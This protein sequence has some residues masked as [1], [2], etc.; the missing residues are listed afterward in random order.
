MRGGKKNNG[1]LVHFCVM[2]RNVFFFV[3]IF[4][5]SFLVLNPDDLFRTS[6]ATPISVYT[7]IARK[8]PNEKCTIFSPVILV[9]S[10]AIWSS[11]HS[12]SGQWLVCNMDQSQP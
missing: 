2:L 1:V 9:G 11:S 6:T 8:D 4:E 3:S 7:G 5:V 10:V 12:P